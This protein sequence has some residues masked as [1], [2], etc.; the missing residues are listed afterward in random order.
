MKKLLFT[1]AILFGL[2]LGFSDAPKAAPDVTPGG[3]GDCLPPYTELYCDHLCAITGCTEAEQIE[4]SNT[5][6]DIYCSE[7]LN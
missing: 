1:A 2:Q 6:C 3:N 5:W 7:W 4:E